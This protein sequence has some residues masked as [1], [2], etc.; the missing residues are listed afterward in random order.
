MTRYHSE[1]ATEA[2]RADEVAIRALCDRYT[3]AVNQRDWPVYRETWAED[4]L[5]DLG[6]PVNQ[7]KA[8]IEA[9]MAEV[10][11]AVGG[12]D[13]FVQMPHAFTLLHLAAD[14][15]EA[16]VTLNEV[17]RIRADSRDLLGGADGMNILAIY[18]DAL[19]RG[20]DQRWRFSR[21]EYKVL[22]FNGQ[23]PQGQ[24]LDQ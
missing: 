22:L 12:M 2:E 4:G 19:V 17:G 18:T 15:A 16:R 20:Q 10:Q 9:I 6:P 3:D 5:W 14:R 8:G 11:R 24:V 1:T 23:A 21:R 13:L 7:R